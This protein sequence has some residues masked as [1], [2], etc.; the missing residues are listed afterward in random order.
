MLVFFL[1]SIVWAGEIL[2]REG[3]L[4]PLQRLWQDYP[5]RH[6]EMPYINKYYFIVQIAYWL[7]AFPELYFQKVKRDELVHRASYSLLYLFLFIAA[8]YLK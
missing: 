2:R 4:L 1:L 6:V 3:F 7:H 8:Y 5:E